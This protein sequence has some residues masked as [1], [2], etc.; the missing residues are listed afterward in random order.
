MSGLEALDRD[1]RHRAQGWGF[2]VDNGA[3]AFAHLDDVLARQEVAGL[4]VALRLE[5]IVVF[6][7]LH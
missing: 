4:D 5:K 7:L 1:A 3:V 6:E 2:A